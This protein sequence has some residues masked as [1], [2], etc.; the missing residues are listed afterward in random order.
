MCVGPTPEWVAAHRVRSPWTVEATASD[1]EAGAPVVVRVPAEGFATIRFTAPPL[2]RCARADLGRP[3]GFAIPTDDRGN[4]TFMM[5]APRRASATTP[6]AERIATYACAPVNGGRPQYLRFRFVHADGVGTPDS[7]LPVALT[8]ETLRAAIARLGFDPRTATI[9]QLD[10][11]FI[12]HPPRIAHDSVGYRDW[13]KGAIVPVAR[14]P[15]P[16]FPPSNVRG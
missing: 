2:S 14:F 1:D 12:G 16:K 11:A 6:H 15:C 3:S 4:G 5:R 9:A 7:T 13:L 8:P 10:A